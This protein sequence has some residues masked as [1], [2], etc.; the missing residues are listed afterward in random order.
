MTTK[1]KPKPALWPKPRK[2]KPKPHTR[3]VTVKGWAIKNTRTGK[4]VSRVMSKADTRVVLP[5]S[6]PWFR[7]VRAT[8]TYEEPTP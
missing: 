4:V 8:L 7:V 1:R 6:V 2:V 3:T 5:V